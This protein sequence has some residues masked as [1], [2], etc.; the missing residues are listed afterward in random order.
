MNDCL[1]VTDYSKK[2]SQ[3]CISCV[4]GK[5][6]SE[7]GNQP[8]ENS[9]QDT[10]GISQSSS[11]AS[12]SSSMCRCAQGSFGPSGGSC[13]VCQNGKYKSNIE[14]GMCD[15]FCPLNMTSPMMCKMF[16]DNRKS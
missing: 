4:P 15:E 1:C 7:L 8:C 16:I 9:P 14:L 13:V 6:K 10:S 5:Y 2:G 12:V 11:P 3:P